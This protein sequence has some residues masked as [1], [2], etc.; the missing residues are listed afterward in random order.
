MSAVLAV[1]A[2][3]FRACV[4]ARL[5]LLMPLVFLAAAASRAFVAAPTPAE[6]A[7]QADRAL[8]ALVSG[9]AVLVAAVPAA[10]ALPVDIR[11][12]R[13]HA[14]LAA[15][16]SRFQFVLG[17]V[18]GHGAFAALLAAGMSGAAL[19]GLDLAGLGSGVRE[20]SRA[21]SAVELPEDGAVLERGH[22]T[23]ALPFRVP[24]G[25]GARD[26][27]RVRVTPRL[28]H[29]SGDYPFAETCRIGVGVP[30]RAIADRSVRF[31]L[32]LPFTVD[33]PLEGLE[34]GDTGELR[35]H[36]GT[37]SWK[38]S[39]VSVEVG[40]GPRLFT[41]D[42][43]LGV[44]TLTPLL[45]LLSAAALCGAARFGPPTACATVLAVA[46]LLASQDILRDSAQFVL[47]IARSDQAEAER[48]HA[49]GGH[50]HDVERVSPAQIAIARVTLR[51]LSVVPPLETFDRSDALV[52]RRAGDLEQ[53]GR[54]AGAAAIPFVLALCVAWLGFRR[55]EI[56]PL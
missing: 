9:L 4:A 15:P 31:G 16:V 39:L 3:R 22:D 14:L 12:G 30:G 13:A 41:L 2:L 42:V 19:L 6:M 18:L 56:L 43:L 5:A 1:A 46:A 47:Q 55:R 26:K 51:A 40:G 49:A 11:R 34:A 50:E 52:Q 21:Y 37:E 53:V 27:L 38:L 48:E 54:A 44:A 33:L 23:V 32:N 28:I 24:D 29:Q 35:L 25:L 7:A 17:D 36:G 45:F 8:L 20:S 10:L